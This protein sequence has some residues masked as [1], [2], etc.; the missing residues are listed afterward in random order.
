MQFAAIAHASQHDFNSTDLLCITH[1]ETDQFSNLL[2]TTQPEPTTQNPAIR[3]SLLEH[4]QSFFQSLASYSSR[5]PP[6]LTH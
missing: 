2:H 1:I 5:A 3:H 6:S 4:E